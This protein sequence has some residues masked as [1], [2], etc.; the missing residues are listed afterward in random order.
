MASE[1]PQVVAA[2]RRLREQRDSSSFEPIYLH[3]FPSLR[4]NFLKR[5][6]PEAAAEE[7]AQ[8]AL[9][10]VWTNLDQYREDGPFSAW[11]ARIAAN[12]WK[13]AVR[14]RK[15]KKRRGQ[16]EELSETVLDSKSQPLFTEPEPSAE[17]R[18]ARTETN[19]RLHGALTE[20]PS[21]MR[22]C[23]EL[24]VGNDLSYQEIADT[25]GVGLGTVRSQIHDGK[26]RLRE[27]LGPNLD[28]L[29]F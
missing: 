6:F 3:Y 24:R 8:E 25:L 2:L 1:P 11:V 16:E 5:G 12:L 27:I 17:T 22:A 29:N 9:F 19:R 13:N 26:K 20:L 18:V 10:V 21:G 7:L 14:D 28:E 4:A 23:L 15:A